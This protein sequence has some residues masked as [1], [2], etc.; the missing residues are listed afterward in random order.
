[1]KSLVNLLEASGVGGA[2]LVVADN[3]AI[4]SGGPA[5][6]ADLAGRVHRV[7]LTT[8]AGPAAVAGVV[9][10]ALSLGAAVIVAAG[11]EAPR[12]VAREAARQLGLPGL[13]L[14]PAAAGDA[15]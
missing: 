9:A 1:M 6:A 15:G 2:V 3:E 13:A 14:D 4:A 11:G 5:W 8:A 10:E 12:L 7:R